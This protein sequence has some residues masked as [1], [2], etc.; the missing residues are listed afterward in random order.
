[1]TEWREQLRMLS[2]RCGFTGEGVFIAVFT[3]A[4]ETGPA[5]TR[6]H[7]LPS[8]SILPVDSSRLHL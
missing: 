3:P 2:V 4:S 6:S 5:L 1:M 7:K 8:V